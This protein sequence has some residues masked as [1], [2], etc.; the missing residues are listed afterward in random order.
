MELDTSHTQLEGQAPE[1]FQ[2]RF[3]GNDVTPETIPVRELG[4]AIIQFENAIRIIVEKRHPNVKHP[5]LFLTS[6]DFESCGWRFFPDAKSFAV[7]AIL[8]IC[9]A[10]SSGDFSEI[11]YDALGCLDPIVRIAKKHKCLGEINQYSGI[12]KSSLVGFGPQTEIVRPKERT[13]KGETSIFAFVQWAGGQKP[14]IHVVLPDESLLN[15]ESTREVIKQIK[16]YEWYTFHGT[17][18]W[19]L[20]TDKMVSLSISSATRNETESALTAF[21]EISAKLGHIFDDENPDEF[22]RRMR[23]S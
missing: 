8:S 5:S 9:T 15:C 13:I 1:A 10:I 6:V 16:I 17:A 14:K 21:T 18:V 2:I 11:P 3:V 12:T 7:P 22:A 20:N 4:E 19:D 23:D